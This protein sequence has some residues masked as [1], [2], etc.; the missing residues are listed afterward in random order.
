[1]RYTRAFVRRGA[2][3]SIRACAPL[4]IPIALFG[5]VFFEKQW[6]LQNI[7]SVLVGLAAG[8]IFVRTKQ[9]SVT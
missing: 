7:G 5:L 3:L 1:M 2:S 8:V 6:S 4:Q 9:L